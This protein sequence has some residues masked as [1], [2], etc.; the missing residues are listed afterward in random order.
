[1]NRLAM[2]LMMLKVGLG[3]SRMAGVSGRFSHWLPLKNSVLVSTSAYWLGTSR[4]L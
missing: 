2:R 3:S 1:M 4:S